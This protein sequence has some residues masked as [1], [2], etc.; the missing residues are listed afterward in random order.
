M[1]GM[2][3]FCIAIDKNCTDFGLP[4]T[5]IRT[6][7]TYSVEIYPQKADLIRLGQVLLS[8]FLLNSLY[9]NFNP[10]L[11]LTI[12]KKLANPSPRRK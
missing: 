1:I 10:G 8:L 6:K 3:M 5:Y 2:K 9:I 11:Q 7:E 12:E 4:Q